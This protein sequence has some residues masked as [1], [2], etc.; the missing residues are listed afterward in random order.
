MNIVEV[1]ITEFKRE[2]HMSTVKKKKKNKKK[3]AGRKGTEK[4]R[5]DIRSTSKM[6]CEQYSVFLPYNVNR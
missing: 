2:V 5:A 6:Y 3:N 1:N 4:K